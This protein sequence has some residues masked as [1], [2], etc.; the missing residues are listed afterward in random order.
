MKL[1][2]LLVVFTVLSVGSMLYSQE[3]KVL[4]TQGLFSIEDKEELLKIESTIRNNPSI[5]IVRL[6]NHS[7][8]FSFLPRE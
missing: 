8:V 5:S 4:F 7:N 3:D 2:S 1:F 6:D